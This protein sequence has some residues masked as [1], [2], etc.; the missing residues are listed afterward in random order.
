MKRYFFLPV[1]LLCAGCLFTA[2]DPEAEK[3]VEIYNELHSH[4]PQKTVDLQDALSM[5]PPEK[6]V[7]VR[8]AFAKLETVRRYP[9]APELRVWG[10][11][12]RVELNTLLEFLPSDMVDYDT[13]GAWNVPEE[14]S[15]PAAAEKAALIIDGGKSAP[16]ELLKKVRFAHADAV[17]AMN[18][19][20]QTDTPVN[21]YAYVAATIRLAGIVGV[22]PGELDKLEVYEKRFNAA[23]SRW[24]KSRKSE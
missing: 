5:V 19:T 23:S 17:E 14:I 7:A 10:E 16:L 22:E 6:H 4:L 15:H 9:A 1:V 8:L 18:L 2:S 12:A 13:A 20:A 21:R 3:A 11:K 24:Q